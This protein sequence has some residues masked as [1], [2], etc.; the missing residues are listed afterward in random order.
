MPAPLAP[1]TAQFRQRHSEKSRVAIQVAP[2]ATKDQ[3]PSLSAAPILLA[4]SAS[5]VLD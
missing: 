5:R 2:A 3:A 4:V 1:A